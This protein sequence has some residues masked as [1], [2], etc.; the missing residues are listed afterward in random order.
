MVFLQHPAVNEGGFAETQALAKNWDEWRNVVRRSTMQTRRRVTEPVGSKLAIR[1]H[2]KLKVKFKN[3][4][5][6]EHFSSPY[7]P[8]TECQLHILLTCL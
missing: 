4:C 7:L 8:V 1:V 6:G 5:W 2:T 3:I